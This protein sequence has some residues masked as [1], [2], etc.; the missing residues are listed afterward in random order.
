M[1]TLNKNDIIIAGL[2]SAEGGGGRRLVQGEEPSTNMTIVAHFPKQNEKGSFCLLCLP[3]RFQ[4]LQ[5]P[6][7]PSHFPCPFVLPDSCMVLLE[8]PLITPIP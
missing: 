6:E 5:T 4:P 2:Q 3:V 7:Y 8:S 1:L